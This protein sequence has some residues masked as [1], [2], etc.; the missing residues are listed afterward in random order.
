MKIYAMLGISTLPYYGLNLL[1]TLNLLEVY[2]DLKIVEIYTECHDILDITDCDD[3]LGSFNYQYTVHSPT[4]DINISSNIE[5][6][7]Q[8]CLGVIEDYTRR[9]SEINAR[10]VVIHPGYYIGPFKERSIDLHNRSL[11]HISKISAEYGVEIAIENMFW[12][13]SF[14][15]TADEYNEINELFGYPLVLDIG[16]AFLS[17]ELDNFL[18]CHPAELHIHD[19]NGK[20]DE[21][22][23]I[24]LGIINFSK[25]TKLLKDNDA[26]I[27]VK[28]K[29]HA[30]SSIRTL[31]RLVENNQ[32][33]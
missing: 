5:K 28:D 32:D 18:S 15:R 6:I 2:T 7:R 12:P 22:L 27:E 26:V 19:N 31:S 11:S 29:D 13:F 16:H 8:A 23:G 1:E 3:I 30:G 17:G 4:T 25:I 14:V 33:V 9:A 24:G 20:S 21:H 10:R